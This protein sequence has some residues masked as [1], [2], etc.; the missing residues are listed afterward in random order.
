MAER[1]KENPLLHDQYAY[2]LTKYC[3]EN[4]KY[5]QSIERYINQN[6][7]PDQGQKFII[8]TLKD[9]WQKSGAV[10]TYP[11]LK[12]IINSKV[13]NAG[14]QGKLLDEV[15]RMQIAKPIYDGKYIETTYNEYLRWHQCSIVAYDAQECVRKENADVRDSIGERWN[16]ALSIGIEAEVAMTPMMNDD[17]VFSEDNTVHIPTGASFLDE[18]LDGGLAKGALGCLIM[19]TGIGKSSST[20]GFACHAAI[21]GYNVLHFYFE[22]SERDILR[23]YYAYATGIETRDLRKN[24]DARRQ[25]VAIVDANGGRIR[26]AVTEHSR[27]MKMAQGRTTVNDIRRQI[28]LSIANGFKPDLVI[29]D[30]LTCLSPE[31]R[32]DRMKRYEQ[33]EFIMRDAKQ[34]AVDCDVALWIPAQSNRMGVNANLLDL[35]FMGGSYDS[36]TPCD[37]IVTMGKT[38]EQKLDGKC[39]VYMPKNRGGIAGLIWSDVG[40]NNGTC[41]F[42]EPSDDAVDEA[43]MSYS[44]DIA[45]EVYNNSQMN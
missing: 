36:L 11:A 40:F 8:A 21:S 23:K 26:K 27:T 30:Y 13:S 22:D 37:V 35:N 15:Q 33:L 43:F 18:K 44:T 9:Y 7:F 12:A 5:F 25:A 41:R 3:I 45:K 29:I 32:Y 39:S 10:I 4:P 24:D 16:E 19:S 17:F 20:S 1:Q 28:D 31:K 2:D 38:Q 6:D 14:Q 42:T 34:L